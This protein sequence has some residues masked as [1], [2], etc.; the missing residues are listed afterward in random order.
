MGASESLRNDHIEAVAED[1]GSGV[2]EDSL[3][4]AVPDPDRSVAVGEDDGIGSLLHNGL[5]QA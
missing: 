1:F 2:S 3:S 4:A 5:K